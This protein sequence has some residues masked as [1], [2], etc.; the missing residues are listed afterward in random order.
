MKNLDILKNLL[1]NPQKAWLEIEKEPSSLQNIL[2]YQLLVFA[3]FPVAGA[4]LLDVVIGVEMFE[5]VYRKPIIAALISSLLYY[6]AIIMFVFLLAL[7]LKLIAGFF[8][9]K[10]LF[11]SAFKLINYSIY[12]LLIVAILKVI[13]GTSF[14][15][16]IIAIYSVYLFYKG[17]PILIKNQYE[18]SII[19]TTLMM[20]LLIIVLSVLVVLTEL[21]NNSIP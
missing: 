16:Y 8:E 21:F 2:K 5:K 4:F 20:I 15:I 17:L 19:L 12:P 6:I 10:V 14:L 9:S 3:L 1:F 13:P 18:K 7:G 11:I